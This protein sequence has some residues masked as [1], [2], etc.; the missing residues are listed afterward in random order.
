MITGKEIDEKVA[1]LMG[2]IYLYAMERYAQGKANAL[3]EPFD[4]TRVTEPFAALGDL[5]RAALS[6]PTAVSPD[7]S[8]LA[9]E[10]K[11]LCKPGLTR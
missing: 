10:C 1:K 9:K 8:A 5:V 11:R 7:R 6:Q 2:N 3:G 4:T